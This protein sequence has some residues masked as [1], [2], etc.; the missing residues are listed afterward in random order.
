MRLPRNC[1]ACGSHITA[2]RTVG[3]HR[4]AGTAQWSAGTGA[5]GKFSVAAMSSTLIPMP[6]SLVKHRW[7][8][9]GASLWTVFDT[10]FDPTHLPAEQPMLRGQEQ[11]PHHRIPSGLLQQSPVQ[12]PGQLRSRRHTGPPRP[13][14]A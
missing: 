11:Y 8:I 12:R 1:W 4:Q 7:Q 3:M 13:T 14:R 9:S 10:S 6:V 2:S 5:A